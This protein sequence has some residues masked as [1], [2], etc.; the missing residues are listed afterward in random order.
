MCLFLRPRD[1]SV[2]LLAKELVQVLSELLIFA[3][4]LEEEGERG[5]LDEVDLTLIGHQVGNGMRTQKL[6]PTTIS[7]SLL[8]SCT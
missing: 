2:M 8:I 6:L 7:C 4:H 1:K 5:Q 3:S